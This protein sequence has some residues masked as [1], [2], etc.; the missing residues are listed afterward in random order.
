MGMFS[1]CACISPSLSLCSPRN[2]L[3][4]HFY[5]FKSYPLPGSQFLYLSNW[6][7][8]VLIGTKSVL[9]SLLKLCE[10]VAFSPT[11]GARL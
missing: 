5:V 8:E 2:S 7:E 1:K 9:I 11:L 10:L 4:I 3:E 6:E